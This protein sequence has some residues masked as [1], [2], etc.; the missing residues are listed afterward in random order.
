MKVVKYAS[1]GWGDDEVV[2]LAE[3][4]PL[5]TSATELNLDN[6]KNISDLGQRPLR[7]RLPRARCRSSRD[8]PST[9]PDWR[10]GP[11]PR[12][13]GWEGRAAGAQAVQLRSNQVGDDGAVARGGGWEGRRRAQGTQP[14]HQPGWR[15]GAVAPRR[16]LGRARCRAQGT[17]LY[18]NQIGDDGAVA[19]A[20]AVGKGALPKKLEDSGS[21]ATSFQKAKDAWGGQGQRSGLT[22]LYNLFVCTLKQKYS[23]TTL[24]LITPSS[25]SASPEPLPPAA[26]NS[27]SCHTPS[28]TQSHA[29]RRS[30]L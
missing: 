15:R 29:R 22:V 17:Q 8:S 26:Q 11:G 7:R 4:L 27:P 25:T 13:G 28:C 19:L 16:R 24:L 18:A 23:L 2:Q 10:R 30:S 12:G 14:L 6:N 9:Q 5:C 1:I 20:E 3:V 21:T